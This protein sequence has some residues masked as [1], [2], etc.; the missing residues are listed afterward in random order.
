MNR[1]DALTL[2]LGAFA[3]IFIVLCFFTNVVCGM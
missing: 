1:H 2:T 3:A